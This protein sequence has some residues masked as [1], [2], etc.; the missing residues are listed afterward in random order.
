MDK[1]SK[2]L[3]EK[4]VAHNQIGR[5]IKQKIDAKNPKAEYCSMTAMMFEIIPPQQ[6]SV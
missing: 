1:I 4:T 2:A 5:L 3:Y 6:L